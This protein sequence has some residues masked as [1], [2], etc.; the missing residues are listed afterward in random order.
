M[1]ID[2]VQVSNHCD[3]DGKELEEGPFISVSPPIPAEINPLPG[4]CCRELFKNELL[5]VLELL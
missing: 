2:A 3:W 5:D 4:A 1:V